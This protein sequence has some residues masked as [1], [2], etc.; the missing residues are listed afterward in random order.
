MRQTKTF[1]KNKR[2]TVR[3][4]FAW[5]MEPLTYATRKEHMDMLET[6]KALRY[7]KRRFT[8]GYARAFLGPHFF[9]GVYTGAE[10]E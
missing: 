1:Y 4:I 8:V 3:Q 10:F 7:R 9:A 5:G 6:D 2:R